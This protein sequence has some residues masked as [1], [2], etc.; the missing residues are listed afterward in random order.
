MKSETRTLTEKLHL[1]A[2]VEKSKPTN[3]SAI[4]GNDISIYPT[5]TPDEI[6]NNIIPLTPK[7]EP[8]SVKP[9]LFDI[10]FNYITYDGPVSD[11]LD[12]IKHEEEKQNEKKKGFFGSI[13]GR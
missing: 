9:V 5:G 8:V 3:K 4:I 12:E 1:L 2:H 13:F 6:L 7:V 11:S 10:G